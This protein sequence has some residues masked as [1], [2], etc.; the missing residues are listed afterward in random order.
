MTTSELAP[1]HANGPDT[2]LRRG[3]RKVFVEYYRKIGT[4]FRLGRFG[5][6]H[7]YRTEGAGFFYNSVLYLF[8]WNSETN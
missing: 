4:M 8:K 1:E 5:G 3:Q 2:P 7:R 6:A